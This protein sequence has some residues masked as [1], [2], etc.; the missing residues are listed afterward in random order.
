[1][2]MARLTLTNDGSVERLEGGKQVG[3]SRF[4]S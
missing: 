3:V 1:M 2:T 4:P